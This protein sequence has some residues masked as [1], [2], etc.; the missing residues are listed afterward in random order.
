MEQVSQ[1][2]ELINEVYQEYL[3]ERAEFARQEERDRIKVQNNLINNLK[4]EIV[5]EISEENQSLLK[6]SFGY[7]E[8][9]HESAFVSLY[10]LDMS[11]KYLKEG[12][13]HFWELTS[14]IIDRGI[15]DYVQ[16]D[17]VN[18][19]QLLKA[20]LILLG[21]RKEKLREIQLSSRA[22]IER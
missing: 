21:K 5:Q 19:G 16:V 13:N 9:H 18:R 15:I 3:E 4:L 2:D 22:Y 11:I 14:S 1:L 10:G 6:M 17:C 8:V 12:D 7:D 20:I